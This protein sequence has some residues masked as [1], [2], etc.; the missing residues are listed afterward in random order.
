MSDEDYR[1]PYLCKAELK[2]AICEIELRCA[3]QEIEEIKDFLFRHVPDPAAIEA[4]ESARALPAPAPVAGGSGQLVL[5]PALPG[6]SARR[7]APG[8]LRDREFGAERSVHT[9]NQAFGGLA[10][11]TPTTYVSLSLTGSV[12]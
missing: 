10:R 4:T 7:T 5:A 8:S 1:G 11:N 3:R 6:P 12:Y 2:Y 9:R